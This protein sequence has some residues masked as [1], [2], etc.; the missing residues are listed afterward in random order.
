[1]ITETAPGAQT[2]TNSTTNSAKNANPAV[3]ALPSVPWPED[4][5]LPAVNS[6]RLR[7]NG[8][9]GTVLSRVAWFFLFAIPFTVIGTAR[10]LTP[11][12][13]GHGTHIQLGLPPCGF[14]V[15]TGLPCPGCG[16]TTCFSYMTRGQV[17]DAA[18]QNPFGVMLFLCTVTVGVMSVIG[19][20]R[21][22]GVANALD[23]FSADKLA[24][25][26]AISAV[27]VWGVRLVTEIGGL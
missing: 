14:Y 1:M 25:L 24:V 20:V 17:F 5:P 3:G 16:L 10:Y 15:A 18:M 7:S 22:W 27:L 11:N 9:G 8:E 6:L 19:F 2:E 13:T 23:R 12:P 4:V 26:L 21:G